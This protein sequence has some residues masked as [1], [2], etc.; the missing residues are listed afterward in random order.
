MFRGVGSHKQCFVEK[1]QLDRW[2]GLVQI[3]SLLCRQLVLEES[4][5]SVC[6][7]VSVCCCSVKIFASKRNAPSLRAPCAETRLTVYRALRSEDISES[8]NSFDTGAIFRTRVGQ[9][10]SRNAFVASILSLERNPS[11]GKIFCMTPKLR[12]FL[13]KCSLVSRNS[14]FRALPGAHAPQGCI[15]PGYE[16]A[17]DS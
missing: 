6:P 11:G 15:R 10:L 7:F 2:V 4:L 12:K 16:Y 3:I 5:R 13:K 9:D 1:F 17:Y 14:I 8:V